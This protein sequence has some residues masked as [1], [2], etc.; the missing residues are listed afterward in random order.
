MIVIEKWNSKRPVT[1]VYYDGHKK[2]FFVKRFLIES[3]ERK[4]GFITD[5]ADSFLELAVTDQYPMIDL[6][7][8]KVK[9]GTQRDNEQINLSEFIMIKG[10]KA[11]GNRLSAHKIKNIDILDPLEEDGEL[12]E[13]Q[14]DQSENEV[15]IEL[16]GSIEEAPEIN[17]EE[18]KDDAPTDEELPLEEEKKASVRKKGKS[19]PDSQI[20][21]D[22]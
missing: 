16:D 14:E 12:D 11:L 20:K 6:S 5:H 15:V 17:E 2:Q 22:I 19:N 21:L 3:T 9:S 4:V 8:A 18:L 10:Y 1:A 7:F 13:Q